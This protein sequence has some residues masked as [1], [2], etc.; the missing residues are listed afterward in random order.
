MTATATERGYTP[1]RTE[2]TIVDLSVTGTVPEY[3]DGRYVRIGPNPIDGFDPETDHLFTGDGMVHGV[4]LRDGRAEWY[5]NRW[6]RTASVSR[7]LGERPRAGRAHAG[8]EFAV[9][10]NVLG[11]AGRTLA[12]VEG[13][14]RPYELTD[15]LETVG[16]CDFDGTLPGGYTAHPHRDP[17]TGELHAVS[18]FFGWGNRVQYSVLTASGRIRRIVDVEVG[19]SPMMHDFALTDRHVILF[20]L[21]VTFDPRLA[22]RGMPRWL[23]RPGRSLL[24]RMVGRTPIPEP[25][26]ARAAWL[27]SRYT[28][29]LGVPYSWNPDYPAR[30]GVLPRDAGS[31]GVRW[32]EIAPCFVFHQ[33]NAYED[34]DVIVVD[35][36]RH[37]KMFAG[38]AVAG[39]GVAVLERWRIDPASGT[40]AQDVV[41]D[42]P[43]EFPRA[44][45]RLVGRRHRYGYSVGA[46]TGAGR[47]LLLDVDPDVLF[48]HDLAT[49]AT[50]VHRFGPGRAAGEFVFVPASDDAD[51]DEGVLM[52]YV[53]D[54]A[55]G[56][57]DLALIDAQTLETVG[58]VHLTVRVPSGFHG[59]W[60]PAAS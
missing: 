60:I 53:H 33:L 41:D 15:E 17:D 11:H 1:V 38:G 23:A 52:G 55:T 3:L 54:L 40:V 31:G 28:S 24:S 8:M 48:K 20:D 47:E 9:N 6:V 37:P 22:T 44:D 5:R 25:V 39:E 26:V 19:G 35:V 18:Y 14:T 57:S 45:E 27:G 2:H 13:G 7:A 29:R 58:L 21:P 56:R 49:G 10:T 34:G 4:R 16:A 51:E 12:L 32:F 50:D 43:Q 42:R 46:D 36:I 59:N 30:V